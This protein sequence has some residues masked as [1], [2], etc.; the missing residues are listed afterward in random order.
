M[1][2][3]IVLLFGV[4]FLAGCSAPTAYRKVVTVEKDG[5]GKIVK[6]TVVEE[7]SQSNLNEGVQHPKHLDQ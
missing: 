3:L 7:V 4:I 2:K 5:E 1:R 6:T